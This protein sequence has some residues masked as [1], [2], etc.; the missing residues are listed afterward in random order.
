[1]V[2]AR[3]VETRERLLSATVEVLVERGYGATSLAA[4]CRAAGVSKGALLHHFP[5]RAEL[6][7]AAVEHL[8]ERRRAE[9]AGSVDGADLEGVLAAL[10]EIYA[11]PTLSAWL[12]L[13]VAARSDEELRAAV[14]GVD[15]RF[16]AGASQ[17]FAEL[18]GVSEAEAVVGAR[19]VTALLDGLA[20]NRVL[21]GEDSLGP[22]VLDAFRPLLATWLEEKR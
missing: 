20:L 5:T 12:E 17:T 11:G 4:V 10:R 22:E 18:F 6:V 21:T 19:L 13:V 16:L 9:L 7:S 14:A 2:Q 8:F 1:M 3:S 15:A